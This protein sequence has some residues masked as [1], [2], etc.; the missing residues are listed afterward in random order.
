V[1]RFID[2]GTLRDRPPA[3]RADGDIGQSLLDA[4]VRDP[5]VAPFVPSVDVRDGVVVLT[6]VAPNPDAA[7]AAGEDAR[8]VP[9]VVEVRDDIKSAPTV[10]AESDARVREEVAAAIARDEHLA[11]LGLQ[12]EVLRGRVFLRGAVPSETDRLHAIALASSAAGARDVDDGLV[13]VPRPGVTNP[14]PR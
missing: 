11:S 12:V 9:G 14:Q 8:H 1:E 2:D 7:R 13:L 3:P 5:R 4:Y 6:G 10:L